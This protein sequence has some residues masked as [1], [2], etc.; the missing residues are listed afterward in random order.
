MNRMLAFMLGVCGLLLRLYPRAMRREFGAEMRE[1]CTARITGASRHGWVSVLR[2]SSDEVSGLAAGVCRAWWTALRDAPWTVHQRVVAAAMLILVS[3]LVSNRALVATYF[4]DLANIEGGGLANRVACRLT[5]DP[6]AMRTGMPLSAL[7]LVLTL[8]VL[9]WSR[10]VR[11][12]ATLRAA[13]Y[14]PLLRREL[15][16]T[17][18]M[19]LLYRVLVHV[20][21]PH[22]DSLGIQ[23]LV[24]NN[25]LLSLLNLMT[26]GA[27][28]N[29]SIVTLGVY[30]HLAALLIARLV[31]PWLSAWRARSMHGAVAGSHKNRVV[32]GLT[33]L[34][35]PLPA[36]ALLGMLDRGSQGALF[37]TG[38][39]FSL[40]QNV[41]PTLAILL[42]VTI[43]TLLLAGIATLIDRRGT[44]NGHVLIVVSGI[45]AWSYAY[46]GRFFTGGAAA[47]SLVGMLAFM[48]LMLLTIAITSVGERWRAG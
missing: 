3:G 13:R 26:G 12:I 48:A 32:Y 24:A 23:Q 16:I 31:I 4:C 35:A 40:T 36:Y 19:L 41:V 9:G 46:I 10:R 5:A 18:G 42:S 25:A 39:V 11:W 27:L 45:V 29:V 30:P 43:G 2:V 28:R 15:G 21:V 8:A 33:V 20:P 14:A 6:S 7:V 37:Q 47:N 1:V 34:L 44:G 17:L 22:T 38:F